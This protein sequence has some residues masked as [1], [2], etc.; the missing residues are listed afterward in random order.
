MSIE[1]LRKHTDMSHPD[2]TNLVKAESLIQEVAASLNEYI[3]QAENATKVISISNA[4]I[5]L[6]EVT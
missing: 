6:K 3:R 2:F 5:G 4:F 1:D